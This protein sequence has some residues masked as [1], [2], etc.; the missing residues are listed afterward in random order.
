MHWLCVVVAGWIT[1]DLTSATLASNEN[2]SRLSMKSFAFCASPLISNVKMDR[3]RS[4][5]ISYKAPAEPDLWIQTDDEL[6][7]PA[8]GYLS[9]E[10][11]SVHSLH[12]VQHEVTVFQ[13]PEGK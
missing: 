11:L 1:R 2:S 13:V 4:G 10:Q 12:G 7:L 3:R 9:T 5:N 6:S 8:D